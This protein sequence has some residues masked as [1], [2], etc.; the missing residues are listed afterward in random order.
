M[1]LLLDTHLLLWSMG[2]T[3][4]LSRT[5]RDL[6]LDPANTVLFSAASVWEIAIKSSLRRRDFK[7]ELPGFVRALKRAGFSELPVRT[8]HAMRVAQLPDLHKDPFDRLLVAQALV[9]PAV[10]LTIDAQL[11]DYGPQ[12]RVL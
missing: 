1:R 2:V 7:V 5:A 11:R 3:R 10:L 4:R 9:E 8:V 12:V 6:L